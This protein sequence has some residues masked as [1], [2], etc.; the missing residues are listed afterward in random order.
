MITIPLNASVELINTKVKFR[1]IVRD[2]D[3]LTID[4][5]P[6]VGDGEG[7]TSLEL[8]LI[9]L[10][11]CVGTSI[12][13]TLRRMQKTILSF[14]IDSQ[15]TRKEEHPTGFRIIQLSICIESPD[16]TPGDM[17]KVLELSEKICPV[18]SMIK[19]N[20]EVLISFCINESDVVG[21]KEFS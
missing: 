14:R 1:G 6:P 11:T 10:S 4:Y 7:Y 19:G 8:L 3:P 16:V 9:S 21:E 12:A 2:N 15:G 13:A 18:W 5:I 17:E 20:T